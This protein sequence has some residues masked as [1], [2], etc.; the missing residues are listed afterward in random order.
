MKDSIDFSRYDIPDY[1]KKQL[2]GYIHKG[3]CPCSFLSEILSGN[4]CSIL[5][6]GSQGEVSFKQIV[7]FL[8]NELHSSIWGTR[9]KFDKHIE[10]LNKPT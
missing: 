5:I 3:E 9:E 10:S 4:I 2:A 7:R 8:D 6:A 1:Y